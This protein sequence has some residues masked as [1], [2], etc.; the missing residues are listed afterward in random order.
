MLNQLQAKVATYD[1]SMKIPDGNNIHVIYG[2]QKA[3]QEYYFNM[4]K[5]VEMKVEDNKISKL[6]LE[7][8]YEFFV[9]DAS[10]PDRTIKLG[11]ALSIGLRMKI[12]EFLVEFKDI[13]VWS[14]ANLGVIPKEIA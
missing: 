12:V 2:D 1:L 7:G 3:A 14:S 5:D 11:R 6:E 8:E 4:V 9:L 10:F 13:F